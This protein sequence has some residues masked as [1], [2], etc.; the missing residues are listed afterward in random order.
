MADPKVLEQTADNSTRHANFEGARRLAR[1]ADRK[2]FRC[3]TTPD[4]AL[5]HSHGLVIASGE[6]YHVLCKDGPGFRLVRIK[7]DA[8][9][10]WKA[11]NNREKDPDW[12][13]ALH[14]CTE[15]DSLARIGGP[16]R[17]AIRMMEI[18]DQRY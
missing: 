14:Y 5:M 12:L 8:L 9:H 1:K 7:K 10:A 6:S 2:G 3:T 4:S 11:L 18:I 15:H 13:A 17:P 16:R